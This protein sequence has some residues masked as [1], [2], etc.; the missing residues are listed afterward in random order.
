[1]FLDTLIASIQHNLRNNVLY[2]FDIS[3]S[4]NTFSLPLYQAAR[5]PI[6]KPNTFADLF[7]FLK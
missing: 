1:M 5:E 2:L 4:S 7:S 3:S 6:T